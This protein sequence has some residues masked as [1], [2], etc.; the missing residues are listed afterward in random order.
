MT[1]DHFIHLLPAE[2]DAGAT[3]DAF[4]RTIGADPHVLGAVLTGS[5]AREGMATATSDYDVYVV[6]DDQAPEHLMDV[7]GFRSPQLD[8]GVFRL[9]EFREYARAG[10]EASWD[11]YAFVGAKVV[12]DR[13]DG[14]INDLVARKAMLTDEEADQRV[15]DH[16]DAY[17]NSVYR[18]LKNHRDG[19]LTAALLDAAES[20]PYLL[21]VLFALHRR[22]R[23][24]NKY[25]QWELE[26]RPL[27][28]DCWAA[29]AL[30]G[31]LRRIRAD[32]DPA[33]Q[34]SFFI[35]VESAARE[36]GH[37]PML[38][39]WGEDLRFLHSAP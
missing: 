26:Q 38:D 32:A 14:L 21:T 4:L 18:S 13:T 17:T 6:V 34:R 25:L 1:L 33:T 3:F 15:A 29:P 37:G 30:L 31:C 19:R 5:Q 10:H 22:I 36:Q 23:P 8:L 24:Y 11:A 27:S 16:L 2:R 12:F 7:S 39:A 28:G 20:L 9:E 35:R